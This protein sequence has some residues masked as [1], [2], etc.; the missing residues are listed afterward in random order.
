MVLANVNAQN[1]KWGEYSE[2]ELKM[3]SVPFEPEAKVVTLFEEGKTQL[4][5]RNEG[6]IQV[7]G[8][9]TEFHYR[10][11]ILDGNLNNFGNF[12]IPFFRAGEM[13]I[14]NI[15]ELQAQVNYLENG[16]RKLRVLTDDDFKLVELGNG[17]WEY[18]IIFPN[19]TRGS[20]LEYKYIKLDRAYYNLEGWL[21]Q[22]EY[23]KLSSRFSFQVPSFLQYQL[24]MQG[25][26]VKSAL[27]TSKDRDRFFWEIQNIPSIELEPYISS[28]LDYLNLV[29]G[30]LSYNAT[31]SKPAL[32]STWENLGDEIL[33]SKEFQSYLKGTS[34]KKLG[35]DE[36]VFI[37]ESKREI[38]KNIFEFVSSEFIEEPSVFSIPTQ[39]VS[40]LLRKKTGNHMDI[41]LVLLSILKE[42]E[43][44]AN[45]V[46]INQ[47]GLNRTDLIPS[48]NLDQF[49][50]SLV[51]IKI[52]EE[53]LF[54][55]GTDSKIPFGLIGLRKMVP[56]GFLLEKKASH[57]VPIRV[58]H[59][60]MVD[61]RVQ[62]GLDSIGQPEL[63]NELQVTDISVLS[64]LESLNSSKESDFY[65]GP[66]PYLVS[67]ADNFRKER[68]IRSTYH[69]PIKDEGTGILLVEPFSFSAFSK[70]HFTQ[71]ERIYPI[72]FQYPFSET[73]L[74]S[75]DLTGGYSVDEYPEPVSVKTSNNELEFD[76]EVINTADQLILKSTI[77]VNVASVSPRFYYELRKYFNVV[78]SKL[79]EPIILA[80]NLKN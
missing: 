41:N 6:Y 19:S 75:F 49:T 13:Q 53:I 28:P 23:P 4:I 69:L 51:R 52:G 63:R 76:F 57:L 20:I 60:S 36:D 77:S 42:Y 14:E 10:H 2:E 46:L 55:D 7:V 44:D 70:N 58:S 18:R 25:K 31:L 66:E 5:W 78:S 62:M 22:G 61:L 32:Y 67:V 33:S 56:K 30:F 37:G 11:K 3:E 39:T 9:A 64:L 17:Y 79:S 26:E 74:V 59:Q 65:S 1:N 16:E 38:A 15:L 73:I 50:S 68:N 71:E 80:K 34:F 35:F 72:E 47:K 54:L 45:L 48:P 8:I 12:V 24:V 43:I 21:F 40:D 29:E 27:Q